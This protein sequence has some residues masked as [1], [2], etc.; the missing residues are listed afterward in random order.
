MSGDGEAEM[1]REALLAAER[2]QLWELGLE[3]GPPVAAL[4]TIV[5]GGVAFHLKTT[6]DERFAAYSPG[7]QLEVAVLDAFHADPALATIDS[8]VDGDGPSP[9]H[10]LYADRRPIESVV[11][12]LG[13]VRARAASR[14]LSLARG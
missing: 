6:Y 14:V 4:C 7:M 10:R 13:G 9:S 2:V 1:V 12:A 5:A 3:G 8:C 11:V